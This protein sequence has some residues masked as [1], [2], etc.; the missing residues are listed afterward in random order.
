LLIAGG[1]SAD[2]LESLFRLYGRSVLRRAN[3]ILGDGDAAKDVMQEVFARALNA[4]AELPNAAASMGWLYRI[5]TNLCLSGMRDHKRRRRILERWAPPPAV[6]VA[7]GEA[8]SA[9]T[10]HALLRNI[11]DELRELAI[12]YFVDDMSQSEIAALT[13]IPR[14]TV[15]YRLEQF[16]ARAQAAELTVVGVDVLDDEDEPVRMGQA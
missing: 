4:R 1:M 9:L 16:R 10:V 8:D 6:S 14:R 5:T 13:G 3:A 7:A 2:E 12:Y 15:G 11:P